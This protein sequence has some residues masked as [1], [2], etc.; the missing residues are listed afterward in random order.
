MGKLERGDTGINY[1]NPLTGRHFSG[2]LSTRD[3]MYE[4]F[5]DTS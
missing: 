1:E 2:E 4:R 5:T 3:S